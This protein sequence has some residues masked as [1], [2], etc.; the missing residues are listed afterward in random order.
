MSPLPLRNELVDKPDA[1]VVCPGD[2]EDLVSPLTL[3]CVPNGRGR[4]PSLVEFAIIVAVAAVVADESLGE[5]EN[6]GGPSF[7]VGSWTYTLGR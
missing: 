6:S 4:C 7:P 2:V 3:S 1:P 5:S